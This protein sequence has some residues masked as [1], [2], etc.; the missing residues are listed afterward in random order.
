V[1]G[2]AFACPS[3][4]TTCS[5]A[6]N[7]QGTGTVSY[8]V[9]SATGLSSSGSTSYKLD[10]TT[11]QIDGSFSGVAGSNGWYVSDAELNASASDTTSGLA[12]FEISF[13]GS[14]YT[15]YADTT[16]SD[17]VHTVY[18]RATDQAGNQTDTTQTFQID[19]ITPNLGLTVSGTRGWAGWYRTSAKVTPSASDAGSGIAQI[20][21]QVDNGTWTIVTGPVTFTDGYHTY[22]FRATDLAGNVTETPE[23]EI[24]VDATAPDVQLVAE[25]KLG[26]MLYYEVQDDGSELVL[27]EFVIEDED[28]GFE[29]IVWREDIS[30]SYY[31]DGVLWDGKFNGASAPAGTYTLM[32]KAKDA[33]GNETRKLGVITIDLFSFLL[34]IPAFDRPTP[35][36][37]TSSVLREG[38]GETNIQSV[39]DDATTSTAAFGGTVVSRSD[40]TYTKTTFLAPSTTNPLTATDSANIL[41]GAIAAAAVAA[42]LAEWQRKREEEEAAQKAADRAAFEARVEENGRKN[43]N[44]ILSYKERAKAYQ[45]SLDNFKAGLIK[46]GFSEKEAGAIKSKAVLGGSIPSVA[47]VVADRERSRAIEDKMAREDAAEEAHWL[48]MKAAEEAKKAELQA[49]LAAY[50]N[51]MRQGEKEASIKDAISGTPSG[52]TIQSD[53]YEYLKKLS[54]PSWLSISGEGNLERNLFSDKFIGVTNVNRGIGEIMFYEEQNLKISNS[55]MGIRNPKGIVDINVASGDLTLSVGKY[56][57][58]ANPFRAT[59]G[60]TVKTHNIDN[61]NSYREDTIAH[62]WDFNWGWMTNSFVA[63]RT[64]VAIDTTRSNEE[65]QVELRETLEGEVRTLKI[66]GIMVAT[67]FAMVIVSAVGAV[68]GGISIG[69]LILQGIRQ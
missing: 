66:T 43:D 36:G 2:N 9:N 20:E 1:D 63:S 11:P 31:E 26:E 27:L 57:L 33:A 55:V 67:A 32:I 49:G 14:T 25:T 16:L 34:D 6:I 48:A 35:E 24:Y 51:A 28:E 45:A 18:L 38:Q 53:S 29:V 64:N 62:D 47:S 15:T 10:W 61:P 13:D 17:G 69:E 3:G 21:A 42:T 22:E 39:D 68:V 23:Q 8:V 5:I 46:N 56:E 30:G 19:T 37:S 52:T 7:T 60:V 41:W 65:F 58:F 40:N 54:P 12:S 50:Y 59:A 4:D 44:R